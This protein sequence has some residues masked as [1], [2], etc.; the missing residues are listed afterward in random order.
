AFHNGGERKLILLMGVFLWLT[1]FGSYV[2]VAYRGRQEFWK[3]TAVRA[4][5]SVLQLVACIL[6]LAMHG[7]VATVVAALVV[8]MGLGLLPLGSEIRRIKTIKMVSI[9][10]LWIPLRE[11]LPMTCTVIVSAVY[12]N[13]DVVVLAKH[14]SMDEIGRYSVAV[15]TVFGIFIMPVYYFSLASLPALSIRSSGDQILAT[16]KRWLENFARTTLVG[17]LLALGIAVFARPLLRIAFG[18]AFES[19]APVLVMFTLPCFFFYLYTPLAQWMLIQ[20]R[21]AWSVVV[22]IVAAILNVVLVLWWVPIGGI[23]GATFAAL[24]THATLAVGNFGAVIYHSGFTGAESGWAVIIRSIVAM[25]AA[26]L[27][28]TL[29]HRSPVMAGF[30]SCTVFLFLVR[31]PLRHLITDVVSIVKRTLRKADP[32]AIENL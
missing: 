1:D 20:Q 23:W 16:R 8:S 9:D 14:V 28:I 21:Q 26:W 24:V 22:S 12:M 11:C 10:Q 13:Y 19:A 27:I 29:L 4:V 31:D 5:T 32:C 18:H 17:A 30:I 7:D 25:G 2:F 6:A 3:E 15:K